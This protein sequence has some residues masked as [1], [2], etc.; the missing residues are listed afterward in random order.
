MIVNRERQKFDRNVEI[1]DKLKID[2]DSKNDNRSS[3]MLLLKW[4]MS[5]FGLNYFSK[6]NSQKEII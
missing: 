1:Q 2:V 6:R 4:I 5:I 3:L